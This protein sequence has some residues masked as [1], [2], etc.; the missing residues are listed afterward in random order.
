MFKIKQEKT[1]YI[2]LNFNWKDNK[3][4]CHPTLTI[5]WFKFNSGLSSHL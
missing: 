5:K 3:A 2:K 1:K 4:V